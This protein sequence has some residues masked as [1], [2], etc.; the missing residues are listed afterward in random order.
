MHLTQYLADRKMSVSAFAEA[1]GVTPQAVHR[2]LNDERLPQREVMLRIIEV[3]GGEVRPN[4]FF[5][6]AVS[7]PAAQSAA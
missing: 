2:Y 5:G 7:Q 4:D 1:V 3:T 6:P